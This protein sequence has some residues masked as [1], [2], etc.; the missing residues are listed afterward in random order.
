MKEESFL[1]ILSSWSKPRVVHPYHG[2]LEFHVCRKYCR[3]PISFLRLPNAVRRPRYLLR[4]ILTP[5]RWCQV[6]CLIQLTHFM[7]LLV[8]RNSRC[9]WQGPVGDTCFCAIMWVLLRIIG[10]RTD[11]VRCWSQLFERIDSFDRPSS[12]KGEFRLVSGFRVNRRVILRSRGSFI[13]FFVQRKPWLTPEPCTRST[14]SGILIGLT[15][16]N[17]FLWNAY[18]NIFP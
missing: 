7:P 2:W 12:I 13:L 8:N 11:N 4:T 1:R 14:Y 9:F 10:S 3:L 16:I 6:V 5:H 15:D 17:L 18:V